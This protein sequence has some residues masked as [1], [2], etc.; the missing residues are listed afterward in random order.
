M[1]RSVLA[2]LLAG[3]GCASAVRPSPSTPVAAEAPPV[4]QVT[5]EELR[6]DLYAFAD[7]SMRGRETGTEDATRAMR[8][9]VE[10]LTKLGLEPAGDSGFAQRV[11]MQK[12]VFGPETK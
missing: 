10:R 2:L 5:A 9:L 4:G 12:E 7:D 8:F 6:R 3:T 11:P 1:R